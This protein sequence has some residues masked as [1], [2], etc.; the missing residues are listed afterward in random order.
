[1]TKRVENAMKEFRALVVDD[2]EVIRRF[3]IRNLRKSGV[4]E[5]DEASNG[6]EAVSMAAKCTYDIIILDWYMPE[7]NGYE[8]VRILRSSGFSNPILLCTDET[9][10]DK[11]ASAKR[12]G[13]SSVFKKPY[14]PT[15]FRSAIKQLLRMDE[16]SN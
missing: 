14:N 8:A 5:I 11:I 1:M 9:D 13:V 16:Q 12:D 10:S 15:Q 3:H 2:F 7:L 4:N 6:K